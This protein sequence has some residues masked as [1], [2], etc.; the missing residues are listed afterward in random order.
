MLRVHVITLLCVLF[1]LEVFSL[2]ASQPKEDDFV[3][4]DVCKLIFFTI[5]PLMNELYIFYFQMGSWSQGGNTIL[6]VQQSY[7]CPPQMS[8]A[9]CPSWVVTGGITLWR[10]RGSFVA[11]SSTGRAAGSGDPKQALGRKKWSL[12]W[13]TI[14]MIM[15]PGLQTAASAL[16]SLVGT[17]VT[18]QLL[19]H[20]KGPRSRASNLNMIQS[21]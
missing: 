8:P 6:R 14:E 9:H 17:T 12:I 13:I 1:V 15:S 7:I 16:T 19:S 18:R 11:D 10:A 5:L 4:L 21:K 3:G 2:E 20:L